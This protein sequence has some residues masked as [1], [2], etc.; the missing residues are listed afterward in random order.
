M[1]FEQEI[2]QVKD[3]LIV[4]VE[5]QLRQAEVQKMQAEGLAL[6]EQRMQHIDMRLA[7]RVR[8]QFHRQREPR[9]IGE[10]WRD[11]LEHDA[12]LGK[13]RHIANQ[14]LQARGHGSQHTAGSLSRLACEA[15]R[16]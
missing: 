3:T 1:N 12:V 7:E 15:S 9:G 14:F 4:M 6:H 8:H 11:V 10:Q 5:I 16:K 13:I 2:G